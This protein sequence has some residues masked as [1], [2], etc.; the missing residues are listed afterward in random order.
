MKFLENSILFAKNIVIVAIGGTIA[1]EGESSTGAKYSASKI[2]IDQITLAVPGI[3]KLASIK[4]K[5]LMNIASQDI[6]DDSWLEISRTINEL[7]NKK[8]VDG[9]VITHGT[10]TLEETAYFLNLTV[11]STKPVI[12]VGAMRPSTSISTDGMMNLYNA[13]A[14]AASSQAANKGVLVVMNDNIFSSR[15]VSKTSTT[16]LDA[17]R[18]YSLGAIGHINYGKPQIYYSPVRT[19]TKSSAFDVEKFTSLPKVEIVYMYAGQN[20]DIIDSM[21][22]SGTQAIIIAGVGDGNIYKNA[23]SKL[24]DASKKG[25]IIVRSSRTGSGFIEPDVEVNDSAHNFITAD[26]LNPQKARI[27]TKLALTKTNDIEKL[28]EIF[29]KY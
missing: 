18:S 5:Q 28:R 2:S 7:L 27:L 6:D 22:N 15:D 12:M 26:N 16:N 10:D 4:T 13:I 21:V 14:L 11:K 23:L 8:G 17:F 24:I 9:I 1:G 19:H 29:A 25:V 20:A 3:H